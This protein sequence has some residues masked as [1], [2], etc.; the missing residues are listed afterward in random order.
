MCLAALRFAGISRVIFAATQANVASK[1]FIF[2][3]LQIEDFRHGDD[4]A[5]VAGV[6]EARV[7][8][9]YATGSE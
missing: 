2:P 5:I 8:H 6:G 4:F 9:L 3:H 7:L 1:Y